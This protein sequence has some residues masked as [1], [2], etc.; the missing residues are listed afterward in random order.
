VTDT[1]LVGGLAVSSGW[2]S[3]WQGIAWRQAVGGPSAWRFDG[4]KLRVDARLINRNASQ[5]SAQ[6]QALPLAA[7]PP[8][9]KSEDLPQGLVTTR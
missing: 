8:H 9:S 7:M 1:F 2:C 3:T 6:L 5:E 4:A